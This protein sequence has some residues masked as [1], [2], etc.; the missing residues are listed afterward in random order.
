MVP[1]TFLPVS[2]NA[3]SRVNVPM[4]KTDATAQAPAMWLTFHGA[5][6]GSE[7]TESPGRGMARRRFPTADTP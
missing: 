1:S 4:V 7:T 5:P 6:V 2:L 3:A